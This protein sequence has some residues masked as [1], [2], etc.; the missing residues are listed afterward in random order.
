MRAQVRGSQA[1]GWLDEWA[2]LVDGPAPRLVEVLLGEDEHSI[3][4]RQV[5][6]FAGVLT[7]AERT[8]A[9]KAARQRA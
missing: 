7:Q 8:A 1:Q 4:L 5:S 2:N 9:I 3:D 6:P